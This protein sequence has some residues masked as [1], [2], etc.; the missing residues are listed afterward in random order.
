MSRFLIEKRLLVIPAVIVA[1]V[2]AFL[3]MPAEEDPSTTGAGQPAGELV[4]SRDPHVPDLPFDDNPDPNR[5]G[6]PVQWGED[7]RAWLNGEFEGELIQPTVL[8][9]DSHL[10]QSVVASAPHGA[11]VQVV[12]FQ[13]NPVLD[14][15]FVKIPGWQPQEGWVPAPLLSFKPVW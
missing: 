1:A 3:V 15:Y 7:D 12:L 8:L 10:R 13:E 2:V 11:E 9:Y 14:Y 5:C 6:I 4:S